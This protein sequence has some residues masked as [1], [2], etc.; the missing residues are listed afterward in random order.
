MVE[1]RSAGGRDI[2]SDAGKGGAAAFVIGI[3]VKDLLDRLPRSGV[4]YTDSLKDEALLVSSGFRGCYI[5][6]DQDAAFERAAELSLAWLRGLSTRAH[7]AG[8]A[9]ELLFGDEKLPAWALSYDA[10]FEIKG[11][12]FDSIFHAVLAEEICSGASVAVQVFA[13]KENQL[14]AALVE[15]LGAR[16]CVEWCDN[17]VR[18][19]PVTGLSRLIRLWQRFDALVIHS[20]LVGLRVF[21]EKKDG[22]QH[23]IA[24]L[25]S[26]GEMARLS[27]DSKGRL[28]VT[29]IHYENLGAAIDAIS[30]SVVRVGINTPRLTKSG[31][32]NTVLIW[33]LIL[34]GAFRPWFAYAGLKDIFVVFRERHK[35]RAALAAS[36]IA[37]HFRALFTVGNLNFYNL[38]RP[39]LIGMLPTLLASARFHHAIAEHFVRKEKVD[40]VISIESFSNIGRCLASALH[41]HGGQLWGI[42]GGIIS[43]RRVTNVGFYVPALGARKDLIADIFFAWGPSYCKLLAQFGIPAESLRMMGFSRAKRLPERS[44]NGNVKRVMYVT[45]GNAL[46]CPYLMTNEEEYYTLDVLA[47]CLPPGAE[48]LVRAHPRHDAEDFR[49]RLANRPRV[50]ILAASDTSLEDCLANSDCIVGKASTVLLEAAQAG[51]QVLLVN[52]GGTPDFTGFSLGEESLTCATDPDSL[53]YWLAYYLE[54]ADVGTTHKLSKFVAAWCAGSAHSAADTLTDEL[55]AYRINAS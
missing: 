17:D 1:E 29:D 28:C 16:A 34:S 7:P 11:G 49:R 24:L 26:S 50:R 2:Q 33:R 22:E 51:R 39:R 42:Q 23:R 41:R 21:W 52:L 53:R 37:P 5:Y 15:F 18:E 8:K 12:I 20:L 30:P 3:A 45:G 46:V 40:V 19:M 6:R 14:G 43:P 38:L 35:F 4:I 25:G 9:A 31:W 10:L 48:L 13:S 27:R 36:N 55:E 32:R 47:A 44:A 54:H